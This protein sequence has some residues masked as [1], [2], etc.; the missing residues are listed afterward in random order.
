MLKERMEHRN[1]ILWG[2]SGMCF[3]IF[4]GFVIAELM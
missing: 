4:G 2:L 1:I 3:R